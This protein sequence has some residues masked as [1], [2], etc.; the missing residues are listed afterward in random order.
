MSTSDRGAGWTEVFDEVVCVGGPSPKES[1]LRPEAIVQAARQTGCAAVHPGWGFLAENARFAALCEQHG[2]TFVGPSAGTMEMMGL[3]WPAKVAMRRAGLDLTPGSD[4]LLGT[5]DEALAAADSTGYPVI[6]K[7]D[8]G[9]GG[10]GMRIC[11]DADEVR[12]AFPSARAEAIERLRQR[13]ALP[14]EVRHRRASH[15]GPGDRRRRGRRRAPLR[16]RVLD[17]AQ[18]P[19]ADRGEPLPALSP[20]E[21][22]AL[23]ARAARAAAAIDYAGA[24][25]VEFLMPPVEDGAPRRLN[26]M[27]MNTRLQVEHPVTEMVTGVDVVREQ[28]RVAAG[29]AIGFTQDGVS[30]EG[31]SIE[32]RINAEDP[33]DGFRPTPGTLTAF[34]IPTGHGP[35]ASASTPTSPRARRSRPTTTRS[36]PRSSFTRARATRRSTR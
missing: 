1:Y 9:G 29:G 11:Q 24:G 30:L 31:H 20:E 7:A 2:L 35:D 17:P 19:E 33:A 27:E 10:R 3:K 25:T 34:D 21:R 6:I 18:P 32:C 4:G 12:E 8:A 22:E 14:R 36:S 13:R 28:L 15:R 5:V 23:G 26:F 16:A